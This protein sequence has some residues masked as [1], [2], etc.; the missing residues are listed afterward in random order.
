MAGVKINAPVLIQ[1]RK[2]GTAIFSVV[3]LLLQNLSRRHLERGRKKW[4]IKVPQRPR[5]RKQTVGGVGSSNDAC[6][7]DYYMEL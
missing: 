1:Y 2:S 3:V 7:M 5:K 4:P 6:L